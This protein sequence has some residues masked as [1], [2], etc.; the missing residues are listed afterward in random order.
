MERLNLIIAKLDAENK[1]F[2]EENADLK[3]RV[4]ALSKQLDQSFNRRIADLT[5]E[6]EYWKENARG[7]RSRYEDIRQRYEDTLDAL[8]RQMKRIERYEDILRRRRNVHEHLS[9][10]R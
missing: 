9:T 6:L 7:V 3:I 1:E 4:K 2:K 10:A 5:K 8:E